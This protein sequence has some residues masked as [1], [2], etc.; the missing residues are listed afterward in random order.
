MRGDH[1]TAQFG[2]CRGRVNWSNGPCE[3]PEQG[4][5]HASLDGGSPPTSG[6]FLPTGIHLYVVSFSNCLVDGWSMTL[7]GVASAACNA[8]EWSD[9]SAMVSADS[10]RGRGLAFLSQ[11]DDV[12]AE[13]RPCGRAWDQARPRLTARLPAHV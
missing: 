12:T 9:V 7:N 3:F 2:G 13:A 10:V 8:A 5:L 1:I 6:A 4:S 11:L